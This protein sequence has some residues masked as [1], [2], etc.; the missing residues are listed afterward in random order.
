MFHPSDGAK[1]PLG[2]R[3]WSLLVAKLGVVIPGPC[4]IPRIM[5]EGVEVTLHPFLTN[6]L[7][8][9]LGNAMLKQC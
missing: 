2:W 6:F 3:M 1:G 7:T 4:N 5:N 8:T 9:S